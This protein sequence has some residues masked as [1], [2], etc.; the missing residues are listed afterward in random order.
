MIPLVL[1]LALTSP[2][3]AVTH[4]TCGACESRGSLACNRH[5]P[6]EAALE[7]NTLFCSY[8]MKCPACVGT[9]E[10]DCETCTIGDERVAAARTKNEEWRAAQQEHWDRFGHDFPIGRSKHFLLFWSGNKITVKRERLSDHEAMHLYL[11]RLEDLYERFKEATGATDEDFSTVFHV[12]VWKSQKDN[13]LAS[14]YYTNQPNPNITGTKRMGAVGIYTVF[15]DPAIVDPDESASA[16]LYRAVVHNVAHLLLANAWDAR[17]PGQL[18]G[19][20]IDVGVAHYFEDL[21][22]NRCTNFCYRE[23]DTVATFKGGWW[24]GPVKNMLAARK[25][26]AFVDIAVKRTDELTLEEHALSW[27]YCEFLIS[28]NPKGFG[29]ICKAIKRSE[30]YREPMQEHFGYTP[31]SFEDEWAKH[32]RKTYTGR[33]K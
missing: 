7:K 5:E 17:W 11:D 13:R 15:L 24:R 16:D 2:Q 33:K 19:G 29:E 8:V 6:T 9:L 31:L 32:V 3:D 4:D 12:M 25:R 14:E 27:S 20:W 21:L 22:H 26:P 18:Q 28:K 30:S 1:L 23:Q 10:V